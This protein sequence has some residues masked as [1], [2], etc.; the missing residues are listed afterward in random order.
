MIRKINLTSRHFLR[1]AVLVI[2]VLAFWGGSQFLN[3]G[4]PAGQDAVVAEEEGEVVYVTD[5]DTIKVMRGGTKETVRLIGVDT[6]ETKDPRKPVQCFG[7]EASKK[8]TDL[9]LGKHVRLEYDPVAGD[10]DKYG[11]LLRYVFLDDGTNIS[12]Q[13]IF[14]GYAHEY[15]YEA[16]LYKYRDDFTA[17]EEDA[18][19]NKRGLW[20][21]DACSG[22]AD[23]VN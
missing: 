23:S 12:R 11:R 20:A 19:E 5:G 6:P 2:T 21:D 8:T 14:D 3:G 7:R 15:T 13:L 22:F 18:R 17:A 4:K 9:L 1:T 10:K 16:Q